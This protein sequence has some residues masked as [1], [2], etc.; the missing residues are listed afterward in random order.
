MNFDRDEQQQLLS[1]SIE[2][3]LSREYGFEERRRILASESGTSSRVWQGLADLGLLGLSIPVEYGGFGGGA[4]DLIGI[5]EHAGHALLAEPYLATV[6]LGARLVARAG[7]EAQKRAL[8]PPVAEGRLRFA[9]AQIEAG[10]RYDPADVHTR[11]RRRAGGWVIEGEKRLVLHAQHA[12]YLIVS[13][14]TAG[15]ECDGEDIGLFLVDPRA[16]GVTQRAVGSIHGVRGADVALR[17]VEVDDR[18]LI[19][20][21]TGGLEALEEAL[22]FATVLVC[23]EALGAIRYA[24]EATLE[25][26]KTRRQF[27]V[28]I[29]SFQVLQ[30]RMVDMVIAYE[31][32]KSLVYLAASKVDDGCDAGERKRVVSAAK[33]RTAEACRHVSQDAVQLHGGMGL[34]DELKIS[35]AFRRLTMIGQAFGDIDHHLE[36]FAVCSGD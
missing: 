24:N 6:G 10:G 28:P 9:L 7:N 8:L 22:D 4:D 33:I 3:F 17:G 30:H 29:G 31:Q 5:M 13:A 18:A 19:G 14:R 32:V 23:A 20:S 25:H 34:T 36:R 26:I 27:G 16:A 35:H 15:A 2:R 12:S 1:D 11:A 21:E